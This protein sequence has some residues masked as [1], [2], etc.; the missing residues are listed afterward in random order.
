MLK[1]RPSSSLSSLRAARPV[2]S[3]ATNLP[4]SI[5]Q[6]ARFIAAGRSCSTSPVKKRLLSKSLWSSKADT[7]VLSPLQHV[8]RSQNYASMAGHSSNGGEMSS[9]AMA[10]AVA[11]TSSGNT[12]DLDAR[13]APSLA[14][15]DAT[16]LP[17]GYEKAEQGAQF[18]TFLPSIEQSPNDDRSYRLIRLDNG[19]ECMLVSDPTTDKSAAGISVRVGHLSDPENAQGMA[20]FCEHLLFMGTEKVRQLS[21]SIRIT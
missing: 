8:L 18:A 9:S 1:P 2:V 12:H 11:S 16:R 4:Y 20:H 19:I 21:S 7:V 17:L 14:H 13:Y 3:T 15:L 6:A 5:I 10:N